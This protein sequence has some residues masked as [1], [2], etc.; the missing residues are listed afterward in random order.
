MF[1]GSLAV[2]AALAFPQEPQTP[3]AAAPEVRVDDVVVNADRDLRQAV[4]GFI[5][6]VAAPAGHQNLG[7]WN[8]SVCVGTANLK[9]DHARYLIDRVSQVAALVGLTPG[10]AGCR[11]D[12]LVIVTNN[13]T[14]LATGLVEAD[15][16]AF[17]PSL[18]ATNR[19]G[20]ALR[21]FQS[22]ER[23]VRWWHVSIP[24][25]G[26]T[27]Q[28]AVA[29]GGVHEGPSLGSSSALGWEDR[30]IT[31]VVINGGSSR[32]R[33]GIRHDLRRV[34]IIVDAEAL[35]QANF[36]QIADDV[37]MVSLAQLD[38]DADTAR[39][40]TVLNLFE[41]GSN[42][43]GLTQWDFDYLTALY[44]APTDRARRNHQVHAIAEE[45]VRAG[46]TSNSD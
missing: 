37:A 6:E 21:R 20:A 46:Q 42:A 2:A 4:S 8:R 10:G 14:E 39:Y 17:R 31:T 29:L 12:V 9:V 38:P 26:E 40:S 32:L 30:P 28:L 36:L 44:R 23:P 7:V 5:A 24:V 35:G 3:S 25:H 43:R 41:P 13:A 19:G 33:S 45:M 15:R 1:F 18:S 34:V 22:E 27:G 11:P 16:S